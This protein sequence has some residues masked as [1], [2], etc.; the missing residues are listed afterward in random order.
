MTRTAS[1]NNMSVQGMSKSF[2]QLEKDLGVSLFSRRHRSLEL[3]D[4]GEH[5]AAQAR[6]LVSSYDHLADIASLYRAENADPQVSMQLV[7]TP[8]AALCLLPVLD[9]Q[10]PGRV[11]FPVDIWEKDLVDFDEDVANIR[12]GESVGLVTMPGGMMGTQITRSLAAKGLQFETLFFSEIIAL[13]ATSLRFGHEVSTDV[14]S[15]VGQSEIGIASIRDRSVL[16]QL[17]DFVK[18]N[19]IVTVTSNMQLIKSQIRRG[20]AIFLSP[21]LILSTMRE[22]R[23]MTWVPIS[24]AELPKNFSGVVSFGLLSA[25]EGANEKT[26]VLKSTITRCVDEK[27]KKTRLCEY[28]EFP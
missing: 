22:D 11:P 15:L 26:A 10:K 6:E 4:A 17:D 12:A 23:S 2:M 3:S 20:Q 27:I 25:V 28:V 9:L 19:R 24:N 13:V 1:L 14:Q 5:L 18:Y 21:K 8:S 7:A 16:D